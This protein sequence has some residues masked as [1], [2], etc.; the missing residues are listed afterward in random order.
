MSF[1][2][3]GW[4]RRRR[5][6]PSLRRVPDGTAITNEYQLQ[7][8]LFGG[9]ATF[10]AADTANPSSPVLSGTPKFEGTIHGTFVTAG[11]ARTVS[12][13]IIDVGYI[14]TPG[15]VTVTAFNSRGIAIESTPIT[16]LGIVE[17]SMSAP[18]IAA[19]TVSTDG[20][21]GA[22][23]AV[24]ILTFA[25]PTKLDYVSLADSYSSGENAQ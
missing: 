7:G 20:D 9:D 4:P 1:K 8:I 5:R 24:D 10:I 22:G 2:G 25:A 17:V 16:D 15:S 6:S 23:F 21:E 12:G 18:G 19:F 14:D 11:S 3:A 13:F